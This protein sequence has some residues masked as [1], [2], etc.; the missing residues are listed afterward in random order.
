MGN[1]YVGMFG[2]QRNWREEEGGGGGGEREREREKRRKE[3]RGGVVRVS[4]M[5][6]RAWE[7][8]KEDGR[9]GESTSLS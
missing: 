8:G 4:L 1:V 6:V 5:G 9:G 2:R 3:K 7:E